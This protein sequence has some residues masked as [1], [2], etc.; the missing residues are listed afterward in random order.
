MNANGEFP[1]LRDALEKI[2]SKKD[3]DVNAV[4]SAY[5]NGSQ[6]LFI[7][8][9]ILTKSQVID[10]MNIT[11]ALFESNVINVENLELF[12]IIMTKL[13]Q[14]TRGIN[15]LKK[16]I[17]DFL[18]KSLKFFLVDEVCLFNETFWANSGYLCTSDYTTHIP[19]LSKNICTLIDNG[20]IDEDKITAI[21]RLNK[22]K[23]MEPKLALTIL[24][25]FFS[26]PNVIRELSFCQF[27]YKF[28]VHP[29]LRDEIVFKLKFLKTV[30]TTNLQLKEYKKI[31][32]VVQKAFSI[33]PKL[34]PKKRTS[35]DDLFQNKKAKGLSGGQ[36]PMFLPNG[37]LNDKIV[38]KKF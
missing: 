2:T 30:C 19:G 12:F 21:L 17:I 1:Y 6:E 22:S 32:G 7:K 5:L 3:F 33:K 10:Y 11:E 15:V 9:D 8:V 35:M 16:R 28:S 20:E 31:S 24:Y 23:K 34:A 27:G 29:D 38:D 26:S 25:N 4:K 18:P 37:M 14:R 13:V 36:E